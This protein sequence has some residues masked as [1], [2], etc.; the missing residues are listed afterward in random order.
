VTLGIGYLW[1][2]WD[3]KRQTF[4]DIVKAVVVRIDDA[5]T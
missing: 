2:L 3:P 4:T 5:T 1:P